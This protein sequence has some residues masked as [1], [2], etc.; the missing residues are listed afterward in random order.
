MRLSIRGVKKVRDDY[1]IL[2]GWLQTY[3]AYLRIRLIM[4]YPI[5]SV[6][7]NPDLH[8]A[9]PI[10][11]PSFRMPLWDTQ[12][13]VNENQKR[14][15]DHEKELREYY[16]IKRTETKPKRV[17]RSPKY[18]RHWRMNYI[19]RQVMALSACKRRAILLRYE[20]RLSGEEM[21]T[22]LSRSEAAVKS[23]I[24]SAHN[25]LKHIPREMHNY[26]NKMTG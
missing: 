22:V 3:G 1:K 21:A 14:L 10:R 12:L 25:K 16:H 5:E 18:N 17:S 19:D 11:E 24:R 15:D 9:I 20:E 2:R 6:S 23:I 8:T 26:H 7:C 13:S 4:D